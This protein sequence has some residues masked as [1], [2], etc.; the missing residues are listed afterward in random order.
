M[1]ERTEKILK[2]ENL[3]CFG[4]PRYKRSH[5]YVFSFFLSFVLCLLSPVRTFSSAGCHAFVYSPR[6]YYSPLPCIFCLVFRQNVAKRSSEEGGGGL[7]GELLAQIV[8][9]QNSTRG[10]SSCLSC[11]PFDFATDVRENRRVYL[12]I[13]NERE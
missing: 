12:F 9:I 7:Q 4:R 11:L 6:A 5:L 1:N 8:S 2:R 13:W 10:V 3:F